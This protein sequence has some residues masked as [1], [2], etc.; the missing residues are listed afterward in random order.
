MRG[1]ASRAAVRPAAEKPPRR[2][3]RDEVQASLAAEIETLQDRLT[4]IIREQAGRSVLA[5][6]DGI[7]E[8]C[9]RVRA[10]GSP[11]AIR[12]KRA[13]IRRLA[14]PQAYPVV[15]AFSLFFQLANLCEE[16]A[17][18]RSIRSRTGLRQS[19]QTA[20]AELREAGVE[21]AE[22]AH[23]LENLSI[24]PVWTAHPTE[25]KRRSVMHHLMRLGASLE[26]PD[27]MLEALWQ[28]EEVR[29]HH[30]T[31][32]DEVNT[33][34]YLFDHAVFEATADFYAALQ[35][36]MD[37][38]FPGLTCDRPVLR[39]A[40]WIGGDRDGHPM[41]TPEVS[42]EALRR[43]RATVMGHYDE[44]CRLLEEELTHAD[45]RVPV[46]AGNTG[47]DPFHPAETFRSAIAAMRRRLAEG[48]CRSAEDWQRELE[49]I[50]AG[51][52]AQGARRAADGR[53]LRLIRKVRVFGF[54]LAELDFRDHSG[55]LASAP[56][57][58]DRELD[59]LHGLQEEH[60]EVAIHRFILSMTHSA[61][62]ILD[63]LGRAARKGLDRLDVVP[64]FETISD[65]ERAPA[66]MAELWGHADYRRHLERRG[67][68]QEVMLG[69]SDSNKDGGYLAANWHLYQAQKGLCQ[70]ADRRGIRIRFFHGKGGTIDRGGG[71]SYRS[72]LAQ[73]HAS[74]D[75]AVRITEQGEVV[76]AK[77]ANRDIAVRNLEQ[78]ASA[79]IHNQLLH[80]ESRR[81]DPRWEHLLEGLAHSSFRC[82]RHLIELEGFIEY[83]LEAT[84]IDL[85]EH[86]RIGSRPSRRVL[87]GGLSDLR[88]IPW[89]MAWTQSRHLVPAWY[90]I[91]TALAEW[92]PTRADELRRLYR[93]WPFFAMLMD[94]AEVSLAKADMYI[95]GRYASLV[96]RTTLRR[97]I[98]GQIRDEHERTTSALLAV[99]GHPRLLAGQP[100]LAE[101]MRLRT[102][103][104]D[105]L[106]YLQ[107]R[108]LRSWRATPPARRSEPERRLLAL[109]VNGIAF[110]MKSTG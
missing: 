59:A 3:I 90:G 10:T 91:G 89:V 29:V 99:T 44:E 52:L 18:V 105:P 41:V 62:Q 67:L 16:R 23:L 87:G 7:R 48:G 58:V 57:E 55:R 70:E 79:V 101:S 95:A 1:I 50:R 21:G 39:F 9:A 24:E 19:L 85:V 40:T 68:V 38:H 51:L 84:P 77:Y 110:A 104:V 102:P 28:T 45:R 56:A 86:T 98:L 42:R 74:H 22:I 46:T 108:F 76:F 82:Y 61:D 33:A 106:H 80:E 12:A 17:R 11:S 53:L 83:F 32:L 93:E 60:G 36:A 13:R 66:L 25:S 49:R 107:I 4:V 54:H 14:L 6:V 96:R 43:M 37:T 35:R 8:A 15:H 65:L 27:P 78:L 73:P 26:D 64:L 30:I 94:N 97:Q 5:R 20:F 81:V 109:T 103:H 34:L 63:V 31:P 69:Y 71:M 88:A 72:L 47:A 2:G 92:L 75:A 100:R